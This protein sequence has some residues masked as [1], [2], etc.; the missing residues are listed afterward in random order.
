VVV[1]ERRYSRPPT[2]KSGVFLDLQGTGISAIPEFSGA[3]PSNCDQPA[4]QMV[5]P[6]KRSN[7]GMNTAFINESQKL[8]PVILRKTGLPLPDFQDRSLRRRRAYRHF[9]LREKQPV[10]ESASG[11]TTVL[12]AGIFE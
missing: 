8:C 9:S 3:A 1:P 10:S 2:L 6:C 7:S 5:L 11:Q 4:G 12:K